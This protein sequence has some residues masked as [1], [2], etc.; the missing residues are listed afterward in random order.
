MLNDNFQT[1]I[2]W[3][4]NIL[5]INITRY[6]FRKRRRQA[7]KYISVEHQCPLQVMNDKAP[8]RTNDKPLKVFLL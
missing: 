2:F 7:F 5:K 1:T 4:Q 8:Q 6:M 3:L